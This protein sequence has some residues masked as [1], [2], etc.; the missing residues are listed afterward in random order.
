MKIEYILKQIEEDVSAGIMRIRASYNKWAF[1]FDCKG[2]WGEVSLY[3]D[4][5]IE[6]TMNNRNG[7]MSRPKMVGIVQA[8]EAR[9]ESMNK[10]IDALLERYGKT[11]L[12]YGL[13]E[14]AIT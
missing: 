3:H 2:S 4:G 5:S 14:K 9:R 8:E 1:E 13:R 10:D 12:Y 11:R 6:Y 7:K